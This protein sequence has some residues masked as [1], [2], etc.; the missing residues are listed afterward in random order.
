MNLLDNINYY[1]GICAD[2]F[3]ECV[4]YIKNVDYLTVLLVLS[5]LC[6]AFEIFGFAR[7]AVGAETMRDHRSRGV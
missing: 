3:A 7:F 5:L 2:I 6:V 1:F 4:N